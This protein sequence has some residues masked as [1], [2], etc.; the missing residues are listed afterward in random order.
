MRTNDY[1][2]GYSD[3]ETMRQLFAL[4]TLKEA[5]FKEGLP[6]RANWILVGRQWFRFH[7]RAV[8][9]LLHRPHHRHAVTVTHTA[10][11]T[12]LSNRADN[13]SHFV[14]CD[15]RD[16]STNWPMTHVTHNRRD[17]SVNWPTWPMWHRT[18]LTTQWKTHD[19][20]DPWPTTYGNCLSSAQSCCTTTADTSWR[21]DFDLIS[22]L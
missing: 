7:L 6:R 12:T 8:S 13:G 16:P 22:Q 21:Q 15:P 2:H 20:R 11:H 3:V 10:C 17:P 1:Q 14:T 5:L 19:P 4:R 18:H 9:R